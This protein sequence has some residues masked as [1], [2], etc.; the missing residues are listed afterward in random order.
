MST[1]SRFACAG[2]ATPSLGVTAVSYECLDIKIAIKSGS[3]RKAAHV[4]A[5]RCEKEKA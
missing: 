4:E 1:G 2:L 5:K 3:E